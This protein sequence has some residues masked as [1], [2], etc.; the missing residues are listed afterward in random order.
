MHV[1]FL[2]LG[3]APNAATKDSRNLLNEVN[4][5]WVKAPRKGAA[6]PKMAMKPV[7]TGCY[8]VPGLASADPIKGSWN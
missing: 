5:H 1:Q 4:L 7:Q 6:V 2:T 3:S 8:R